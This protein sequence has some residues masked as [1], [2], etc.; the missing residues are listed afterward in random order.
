MSDGSS[1][2][3]HR[4]VGRQDEVRGQQ[5][6]VLADERLQAGAA[7][8]LLALEHEL[9]VDRQ[10]PAVAKNASATLIGISIGPLSSDTPRA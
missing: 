4:A 6:R 2:A 7:D 8:L 3:P 1:D 10:G 9:D 5:V